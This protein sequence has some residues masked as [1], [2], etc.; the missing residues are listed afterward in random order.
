MT[1]GVYSDGG[2][3]RLYVHDFKILGKLKRRK[4]IRK[5]LITL[6]SCHQKEAFGTSVI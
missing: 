6:E 5:R 2:N 4:Q 1:L 3:G